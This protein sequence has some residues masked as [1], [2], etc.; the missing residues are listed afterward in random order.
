[1]SSLTG[2]SLADL[3][4]IPI[5]LVALIFVIS[6]FKRQGFMETLTDIVDFCKRAFE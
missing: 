1:M 2:N 5:C 6:F 3:L 4:V